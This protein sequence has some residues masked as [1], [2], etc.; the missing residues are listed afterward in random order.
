MKASELLQDLI[1]PASPP[2]VVEVKDE[3]QSKRDAGYEARRAEVLA[4]LDADAKL[5]R[6]AVFHPDL[7]GPVICTVAV[8]GS[9]GDATVELAIP[10]DRYGDGFLMFKALE[11][12]GVQ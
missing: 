3:V 6:A 8:R 7:P 4:M 5:K 9:G 1:A 11:R 10:R 12:L 2:S